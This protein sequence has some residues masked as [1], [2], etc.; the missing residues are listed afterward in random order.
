MLLFKKMFQKV[1]KLQGRR[2]LSVCIFL[3]SLTPFVEFLPFEPC[4]FE[5][6]KLSCAWGFSPPLFFT[7]SMSAHTCI[8]GPNSQRKKYKLQQYFQHL[9]LTRSF[10]SSPEKSCFLPCVLLF[11]VYNSRALNNSLGSS[12]EETK[13]KKYL[14]KKGIVS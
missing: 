8:T 5:C 9:A 7:E 13:A 4:S 10:S 2:G 6:L 3:F 11:C 14:S 12:Y 1:S